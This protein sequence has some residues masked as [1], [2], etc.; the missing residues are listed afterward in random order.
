MLQKTKSARIIILV[1]VNEYNDE[2]YQLANSNLPF[3]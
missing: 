3:E 2:Q 1:Y